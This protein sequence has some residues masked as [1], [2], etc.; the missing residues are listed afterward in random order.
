MKTLDPVDAIATPT[1]DAAPGAVRGLKVAAATTDSI[2]LTWDPPL[3]SDT[4]PVDRY[5]VIRSVNIFGD[6]RQFV[7]ET[8]LTDIDLDPNS[9]HEYRVR[10]HSADGVEGSEVTVEALTSEATSTT[11][12]TDAAP[13]AVRGL[14]VAAATTDSITLTWDPPLNSDTVPVD[15]YEVIRSVNIFGDERQFVTETT[16]TDID[17]DPNSKHEYRVRAH[18]ADGVEGSEVTVE[19]LTSEAT[20]TTSTTDAAPGA[21][22][23]LKVAAARE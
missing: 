12:T 17:L 5:E 1:T 22:R 7:T 21:V 20:S 18:S 15:R 9:K 16:L 8:T 23:G 11:P 2:T 6:E 10:A 4:V 19:A 3:N 14:K 13:G